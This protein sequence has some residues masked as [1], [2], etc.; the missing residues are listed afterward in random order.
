MKIL[1]MC[2]FLKLGGKRVYKKFRDKIIKNSKAFNQLKNLAKKK[3]KTISETFHLT[4]HHH[5]FL[6]FGFQYQRWGTDKIPAVLSI[7]KS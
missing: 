4:T 3:K 1:K 7:Y 6:R 2:N 5:H